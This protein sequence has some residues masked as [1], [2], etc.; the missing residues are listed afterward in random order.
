MFEGWLYPLIASYLGHY[1]KGLQKEQARALC[2]ARRKRERPTHAHARVSCAWAYGAA[3]CGWRTWTCASRRVARGRSGSNGRPPAR[4]ICP[5]RASQAF[6]Y[7]Q[8]PFAIRSGTA[9]RLEL[10][11]R[12]SRARVRSCVERGRVHPSAP[13]A[14]KPLW[15][16]FVPS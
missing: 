14:D 4:L 7:L 16:L 11:A 15:R 2:F 9:G 5:L 1:V 8:L 6:E 13:V 3:W 12:P 10:Q